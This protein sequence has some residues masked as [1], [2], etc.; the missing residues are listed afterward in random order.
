LSAFNFI[1][2]TVSIISIIIT[3][4]YKG[5]IITSITSPIP[6]SGL[7]SFQEAVDRHYTIL[8]ASDKDFKESIAD[9]Y[10]LQ[11]PKDGIVTSVS[12]GLNMSGLCEV[13][14]ACS[15]AAEPQ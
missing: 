9:K 5:I 13:L 11:C 12:K 7:S 1:F 15:E 2:I 4:G 14:S 3:N 10:E 8:P 6:E